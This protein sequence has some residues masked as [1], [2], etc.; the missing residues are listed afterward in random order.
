M[1]G[2]ISLPDE[3]M[4]LVVG[5]L[6]DTRDLNSLRLVHPD[7]RNVVLPQLW[8]FVQFRLDPDTREDWPPL[9]CLDDNQKK[10]LSLCSEDPDLYRFISINH[11]RL[12]EFCHWAAE[13]IP[14][15][16]GAAPTPPLSSHDFDNK[17][18]H[19]ELRYVESLLISVPFY[20]PYPESS[21]IQLHNHGTLSYDR[22][23]A[24]FL[25]FLPVLFPNVTLIEVESD[26][27]YDEMEPR[28]P[29]HCYPTLP[30]IFKAFPNATKHLKLSLSRELSL[31]DDLL[32]FDFRIIKLRY[33]YTQIVD[34]TVHTA[35]DDEVTAKVKFG[36][37]PST[38]ERF[39]IDTE[40][41]LVELGD[42][43]AA[44]AKCYKLKMM[45]L[46]VNYPFSSLEWMPESVTE[47]NFCGL[48][49][50]CP[51]YQANSITRL[52][53]CLEE[54]KVFQ[55]LRCPNLE[56]LHIHSTT[57]DMAPCQELVGGLVYCPN[58]KEIKCSGTCAKS[59][60]ALIDAAKWDLE[61]LTLEY[62]PT[63][64]PAD[65]E[66]LSKKCPN[67]KFVW[68]CNQKGNIIEILSRFVLN[69]KKLENVYVTWE[70]WVWKIGPL[71]EQDLI[72]IVDKNKI[73]G[74]YQFLSSHLRN[75]TF[76][77][78]IPEFLAWCNSSLV[79]N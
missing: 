14:S 55:V 42:L 30:R 3:V 23:L 9:M 38:V 54:L 56:F 2:L 33:G 66:I 75:K 49:E 4:R 36:Q 79:T 68:V 27:L 39:E 40:H 6:D 59:I 22:T 17:L 57:P 51:P 24:W 19:P 47:L 63:P 50:T 70:G 61:S 28:S 77:L 53:I 31:F 10:E 64:D 13:T 48:P 26:T 34:N 12:Y 69:C 45:G 72:S 67:L 8:S 76:E 52:A 35:G 37:L 7:L 71:L 1:K 18:L 65:V 78:K 41:R 58:V 43:K 21:R 5:Y 29:E 44:F 32:P 62:D 16:L 15:E 11:T 60:N 20:S 25:E 74:S 46:D 73:F